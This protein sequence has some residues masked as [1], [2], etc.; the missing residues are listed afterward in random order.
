MNSS[1]LS[2]LPIEQRQYT[3]LNPGPVNV[4]NSVRAALSGPDICHREVDFFQLLRLTRDKIVN[5]CNGTSDYAAVILTGS[6]TAALESALISIVPKEGKIL[7]LDNGSYGERISKIAASC[8]I[9]FKHLKF[10]WAKSFDL[11]QI[12]NILEFDP[13]I[14]AIGMV[15]H[16]TS[17]GML[18][19]LNTIGSIAKEYN[20]ELVVDAISS[21]GGEGLNI[22]TDNVTWCIGSSNKCIEGTPGLS[23]ICASHK[24][25]KD[26]TNRPRRGFYLD[27][28]AHYNSQYIKESPLFTPSVQ[29]FYAFERALQILIDEGVKNRN[30][31]YQR[32]A[33]RIRSVLKSLGF[34]FLISEKDMSCALTVV[35]LPKGITYQQL[36]DDLK[37]RGFIIY[38]G[39]DDPNPVFRLATIGQLTDSDIEKFL[40]SFQESIT[41]IN[42]NL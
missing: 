15:H 1:C 24:V 34:K 40:Y 13:T 37:K 35:Y 2:Q 23:F 26:L 33:N 27:L 39:Q 38:T 30:L 25:F 19:P 36:H 6:G 9:P 42:K 10:G 31:R 16:E 4:H 18:N 8:S 11:I 29:T 22:V 5:V 12:R 3:L 17:T 7:V 14:S 32:H 20:K 41:F 21:L 28:G